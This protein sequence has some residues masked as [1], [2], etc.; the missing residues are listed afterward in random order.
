MLEVHPMASFPGNTRVFP[1][2]FPFR[3]RAGLVVAGFLVLLSTAAGPAAASTPVGGW[4]TTDTAWDIA[5]SP[6]IVVANVHVR[7]GATLTIDP[8]VE[9]RFDPSQSLIVDSSHVVA[10][11]TPDSMIVFTRNT[12]ARWGAICAV[13]GTM[14]FRHCKVEWGSQ[15]DYVTLHEGL[16]SH[17]DA[18]TIVE[19]CILQNSGLDA[20]EFENGTVVFRRNQ[21][22]F[23][24]RQGFNSW[25]HCT[26][27][28]ED[29]RV[30]NCF[31][32]AYKFDSLNA[33]EFVFRNNVARDVGDDG[34]DMDNFSFGVVTVRGFEAYNCNDKGISVSRNASSVI[35]ENSVIADANEGFVVTANSNLTVFNCVAYNCNRG[36][37][38]YRKYAVYAGA[39]IYVANAITWNTVEPVY[40]D[41][42][43]TA[44]IF[45]SILDTD[46]PYPGFNNSNADPRF[47]D[48]GSYVFSLA[49]DSPAIDAGFSDGMP[50]RDRL[51]RPRVDVP[52]VP[53]TGALPV[54]YYDIGAYEFMPQAAGVVPAPPVAR[55]SLST[56]PSPAVGPV[57]VAFDLPERREVELAV[58]DS[59][60]RLVER[61]FAGS[62][63]RGPHGI[64][65]GAAAPRGVYFIRLRAGGEEA[66]GKVVRR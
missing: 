21:L 9:V 23:L 33:T 32:D 50:E 62:L 41:S 20:T 39:D 37:S 10:V 53:N 14:T 7:E 15:Q 43:S 52:F 3:A 64:E 26:S 47:E 45:Y 40:V 1:R 61:L 12:G 16:I 57:A 44:T 38:A 11:G 18:T 22:H 24:G 5:G 48:P 34:L 35:V 66:V 31:E 19:D 58:Y 17:F 49:A 28:V 54:P 29:N 25:E 46:T 55:F 60:G 59:V 2:S 4:I 30:T 65:W 13:L 36:F 56:F 6:Y 27:T 8:G 42:V 51:G 63:D